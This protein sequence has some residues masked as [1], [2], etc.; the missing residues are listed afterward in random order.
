[1]RRITITKLS[2]LDGFNPRTRKGCDHLYNNTCTCFTSFNPRTRKGCDRLSYRLNR[3][4][5]RFNPRTRKGC[6]ILI[7]LMTKY[8]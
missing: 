4:Y 7:A 1:M 5:W 8:N 2:P 6:D 3:Q